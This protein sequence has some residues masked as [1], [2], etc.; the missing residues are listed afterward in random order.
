MARR[1]EIV[2][3]LRPL[4][5]LGHN[6]ITLLGAVLTTSSAMTLIA[7]W[8]MEILHG[9]PIHPY[10]GIV[11][12]L[13]LPAVFVAGLILMP[14]GALWRRWK[15]R[16]AGTLP[17]SYPEFN[18]RDPLI[19]RAAL[20]VGLATVANITL[21]SAATYRGV[22]YMDSAQ[23]C[24]E[25]CHSVM[26]PEYTAYRDSPHSRVGCV[27]CHIGPGAPWFVRAKISGVR[28][29]FAVGL[30]S[31]SR[32]IP[33]PVHELRPA[34][35]TCEQCHWPQRFHGDKLLVKPRFA[36]DETN[37]RLT[38]VLVLKLGGRSGG[39]A[40]GIHGHH[41]DTQERIRYF[42][43]DR[44]RLVISRVQYL[45]DDGK[46]IEFASSDAAG[47]E[48]GTP[49]AGEWRTM[50]C[51]DCHN[52]PT[53]A[54][55]LPERAL[56]EL[57]AA[58]QVSTQLP[59]IKKK[60]TEV[61]RADYPDRPT[62]TR[63]IAEALNEFYQVNYPA[64]HEEQ[65]ALLA[66]AVERVQAVYLRNVFPDMNVTWATYPNHLGHEDFPGCF[67][68]HDGAH[69]TPDGRTITQDCDACHNILAYEEANPAIL[70]EMGLR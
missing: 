23:F 63:K 40:T 25:T 48:E 33:S 27:G 37:T 68:C 32:P 6:P 31:Y 60:A 66:A 3:W 52:R 50:D 54:F 55:D 59:F 36:D 35:D 65:R 26:A 15:L 70:E 53:H 64:I 14:G 11:F 69:A 38:T 41:L 28:Q 24:G 19:R 56:D 61:L 57:M 49:I 62:A 13:V 18:L 67:R 1:E 45:D 44:Q 29:I 30:N 42:T 10:T 5:Y 17:E 43:A 22:T 16:R 20:W 21:L 9:G 2:L 34:R 8:V 7:F 39:R 51:M 12:F 58:G 46:T 4:L 47:A